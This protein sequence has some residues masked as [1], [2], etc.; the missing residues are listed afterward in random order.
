MPELA[1]EEDETGAQHE[2]EGKPA[3]HRAAIAVTRGQRREAEGRA[4]DQQQA[5]S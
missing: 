2:G 3:H 5:V 1:L 4:A